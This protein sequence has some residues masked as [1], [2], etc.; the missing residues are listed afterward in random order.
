MTLK[1]SHSILGTLTVS[2]LTLFIASGQES[3]SSL[4][5]LPSDAIT[6]IGNP[7][8]PSVKNGSNRKVIGYT[9]K[10]EGAS[11]N[12]PAYVQLSLRAL[13]IQPETAGIEPGSVRPFSTPATVMRGP[14]QTTDSTYTRV[15]LDAVLFEDGELVGPDTV[16]SFESMTQRINAERHLARRLLAARNSQPS[17]RDAAWSDAI[18]QAKVDTSRHLGGGGMDTDLYLATQA[19]FAKELVG[20]RD[21]KGYDAAYQ[22][23]EISAKF[24][25]VWRKK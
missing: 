20:I 21:K 18:L 8:S 19:G 11:G 22:M 14:G 15:R 25:T 16:R 24:P 1:S 12:G 23:A 13:R 4:V 9:L 17:Q 3:P 2:A 10:F 7:T 6:L 5:G